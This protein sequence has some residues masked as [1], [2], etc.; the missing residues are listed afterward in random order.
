MR[1]LYLKIRVKQTVKQKQKIGDKT[2]RQKKLRVKSKDYIYD[3]NVTLSAF[4][5]NNPGS[6]SFSVNY[7]QQK[8]QFIKNKLALM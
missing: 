4:V 2:T 3:L 8:S 7:G 1:R 5:Y 6:S